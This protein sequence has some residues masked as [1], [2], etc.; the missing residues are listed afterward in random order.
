MREE[1]KIRGGAIRRRVLL[2]EDQ[3]GTGGHGGCRVFGCGSGQR[4]SSCLLLLSL[5]LLLEAFAL[6][7]LQVLQQLLEAG[8]PR[9]HVVAQALLSLSLQ[10]GPPLL[11]RLLLLPALLLPPPPALNHLWHLG[12]ALG[13]ELLPAAEGG[14]VR[15]ATPSQKRSARLPTAHPLVCPH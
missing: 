15:T 1:D 7:L 6:L 4:S 13:N 8:A 10:L 2:G 9:V 12:H 3:S 5:F 14:A 11:V